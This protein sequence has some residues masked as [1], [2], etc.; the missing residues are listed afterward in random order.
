M[1]HFFTKD[2][3]FFRSEGLATLSLCI[4]PY[5]KLSSHSPGCCEILGR[6]FLSTIKRE[7]ITAER[8]C[9]G[10][11]D[12]GDAGVLDGDVRKGVV[13]VDDGG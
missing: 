8:D 6:F 13:D 1:G 5:L 12:G 11:D 4:A 3:A 2:G 10:G 7:N 9:V